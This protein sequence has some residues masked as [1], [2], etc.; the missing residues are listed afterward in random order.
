[1]EGRNYYSI[2]FGISLGGFLGILKTQLINLS[3]SILLLGLRHNTSETIEMIFG[4]ELV[5]KMDKDPQVILE[6]IEKIHKGIDLVNINLKVLNKKIL[7]EMRFFPDLPSLQLLNQ[8][9]LL[10]KLNQ[11][12]LKKY[13]NAESQELADRVLSLEVVS[14]LEGT[15]NS[16]LKMEEFFLNLMDD[17]KIGVSE[18]YSKG[19]REA[20]AILSVGCSETAV[21][22][23]GRTIETMIDDLLI[24]EMK[25]STISNIDLKN[26]KL[27]S[28]IGKLKGISIIEE[29]EFHILQKLKFD[30]NDFGHP[31]DK[32]I[33]FNEAK[34]IILD[35][36]DLI[37]ILE[38]KLESNKIVP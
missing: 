31:F 18:K 13:K 2:G 23:I 30:R 22:V 16:I 35:A 3:N 34:R 8:E 12:F 32:E 28:K 9:T 27:E 20:R 26:T 19:F 24:N 29:K 38:K 5:E 11:R 10:L 17:I 21:F 14:L 15:T 7:E 6:K 4:E 1:M 33:S 36:F 37:K 25:K